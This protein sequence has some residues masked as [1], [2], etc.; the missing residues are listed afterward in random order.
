VSKFDIPPLEFYPWGG[1]E[2]IGSLRGTGWDAVGSWG[3][4]GWDLG[5]WPLVCVAHFD[6]GE[7]GYGVA[8]YVE[9]DVTVYE[10]ATR[11]ERDAKT[12]ELAFF[13]WKRESESWIEGYDSVEQ[14]PARLRGPF[15]WARLERKKEEGE[16]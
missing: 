14:L 9:G 1:Y 11:E 13:H 4:D 15:S 16:Q 3:R 2:W 5:S 10:F 7:R 8:Y 12:D 6:G